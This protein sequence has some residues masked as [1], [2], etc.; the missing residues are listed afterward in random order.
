ML[1][2]VLNRINN[3]VGYGNPDS[4]IWFIGLEEGFNGTQDQLIQRF[5]MLNNLV[6]ADVVR[7]MRGLGDHEQYY[8]V[9]ATTIQNTMKRIVQI[10]LQIDGINSFDNQHILNYQRLMLGRP[11]SNHAI[12]ELSPLPNPN[13]SSWHSFYKSLE[14]PH[15]NSRK[16]YTNYFMPQRIKYL[17]NL[18]ENSET[19]VIVCYSFLKNY[20]NYWEELIG[21]NIYTDYRF[22]RY[23]QVNGRH[24]FV[25]PHASPLA[26]N[27]PGYGG[28]GDTEWEIIRAAI[29]EAYYA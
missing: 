12:L 10:L 5:C 21:S 25:T 20:L 23:Y 14:D 28:V 1:N 22:F 8:G 19:R 3:F 27:I 7:N 15:F 26:N 11:K 24:F 18:I 29:V 9:K 13:M 6:F 2:L 4:K 17:K 16:I